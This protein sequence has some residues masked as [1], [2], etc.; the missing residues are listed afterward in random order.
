MHN[1]ATILNGREKEVSNDGDIKIP[2]KL[3]ENRK[4]RS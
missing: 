4:R 2:E 1:Q 3:K